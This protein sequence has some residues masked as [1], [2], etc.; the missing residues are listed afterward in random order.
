MSEPMRQE[1]MVER[2]VHWCVNGA[3]E[4]LPLHTDI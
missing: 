2:A 4:A 1:I 3:T